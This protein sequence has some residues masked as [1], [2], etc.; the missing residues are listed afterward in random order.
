MA[1]GTGCRPP[2]S[3][4]WR[5]R[6]AGAMR[7]FRHAGRPGRSRR[8][9]ARRGLRSVSATWASIARAGWQQ[10]NMS[11][12]RSSGMAA[13]SLPDARPVP[14][15]ISVRRRITSTGASWRPACDPRRTRL[16]AR[17]RAVVINQAA[18]LRGD[19]RRGA[20]A[21][22]RWRTLLGRPPRRDRGRPGSRPSPRAL[23][24]T[25]PGR[26]A[27]RVGHAPCSVGRTSTARRGDAP[28]GIFAASSM[29][30]SRSVGLEEQEPADRLF[31]VDERT[32]AHQRLPSSTRTVV[33]GSRLQLDADPGLSL[34]DVI[35]VM[36]VW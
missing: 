5:A 12:S 31:D 9:S 34:Q 13:A 14:R 16:M 2:R 33:A 35:R 3:C 17:L 27:R 20:S 36:T 10:R 19:R 15:F 28:P 7:R 21:R 1:S 11:S 4:A 18:G 26:P 8:W 29:A 25:G 32:V 6:S 23:G 22:R 30:A 24:P